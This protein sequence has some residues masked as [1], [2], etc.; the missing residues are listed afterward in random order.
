MKPHLALRFLGGGTL[1]PVRRCRVCGQ[2]LWR[3]TS[4]GGA[5]TYVT[6]DGRRHYTRRCDFTGKAKP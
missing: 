4:A 5:I 3:R 1:D 6:Q 2:D